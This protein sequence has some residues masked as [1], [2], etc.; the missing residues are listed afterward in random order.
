MLTG[1]ALYQGTLTH[2][3]IA[4]PIRIPC[5]RTLPEQLDSPRMALRDSLAD[6]VESPKF[7]HGRSA[8][9]TSGLRVPL[10][11]PRKT[12]FASEAV[13]VGSSCVVL[14]LTVPLLRGPLA[15]HEAEAI[16]FRHTVTKPVDIPATPLRLHVALIRGL[17]Q[18]GHCLVHLVLLLV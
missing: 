15:V 16:V 11:R 5:C 14:A 12:L 2:R 17:P 3:K 6:K 13:M 9:L 8:A 1:S 7:G 10:G 4:L 18:H